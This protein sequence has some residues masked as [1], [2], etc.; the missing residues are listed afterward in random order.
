MRKISLILV[1]IGFA[2]FAIVMQ[3]ATNGSGLTDT[4]DAS[5]GVPSADARA[6]TRAVHA[7]MRNVM[8]HFDDK[9]VAHIRNL[10]G[11]LVPTGD[12]DMPVFDDKNSFSLR[13]AT[14]VIA[15]NTESLTNAFNTYVFAS[16]NAPL[17]DVTMTI[18]DGKLKVKGKLHDKGDI[19]FETDGEL[20]P[21]PDGKLRMQADKIKALHL[22]VKGLMDLIGADL[23]D[24]IKT[25]K[26]P[27][28]SADGNGL[29]FD[30]KEMLPPP[31]ID[32]SVSAV[33][34]QGQNMIL[35][36]GPATA[37][38]RPSRGA[39]GNYMTYRGN[40]LRFG[41]LTASD[42]ELTLVDME[43]K[44]PFDFYLDHYLQQLEAGYTKIDSGFGLR[45]YMKDY[46]KVAKRR[47]AEQQTGQ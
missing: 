32:G 24:F 2:C 33:Q 26:V 36:F 4:V 23:A 28:L 31:H 42:A 13:I 19:P 14:A 25:E 40:Q 18:S 39:N 3:S 35:T 27:G 5:K 9:V 46:D 20:T 43:P 12:N 6:S 16:K 38:T 10:T 34:F 29:I 41:K 44:D 21:T 37:R 15:M 17:K 47:A 11:E 1:G 30:L 8:Y 22:P 45:V 7:E